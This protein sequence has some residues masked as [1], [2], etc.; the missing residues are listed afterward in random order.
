VPTGILDHAFDLLKRRAQWLGCCVMCGP[1]AKWPNLTL[2]GL[3]R[4]LP[5][6][7]NCS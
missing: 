5:R 7:C 4:L 3:N 2:L 1:K 6:N